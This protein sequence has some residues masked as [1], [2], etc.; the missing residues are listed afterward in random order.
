MALDIT[1]LQE[2][3]K[4]VPDLVSTT[5][6]QDSILNRMPV[7]V[8]EYPYSD[9]GK[10]KVRRIISSANLS[11]CC[12]INDGTTKFAE[13]EL[14]AVCIL[15][16]E[17]ICEADMASILRNG[18]IVYTA[19]NE[20]AGSL[21]ELIVREKLQAHIDAIDMLAFLGD[22]TSLDNNLNKLDGWITQAEASLAN[23]DTTTRA[24][25]LNIAT[26]NVWTAFNQ[27]KAALPINARKW[28]QVGVF[29]PEEFVDAY[30]TY[31]INANNFNVMPDLTNSNPYS[32][33]PVVGNSNFILVPVSALNGTGQYM[34]TPFK[35][36]VYLYSRKND[37]NTVSWR[38]SEDLERYVW[39]VK[40]IMGVGFLATAYVVFGE[41]DDSVMTG[42]FAVDVNIVSP[43]GANG[44]VATDDSGVAP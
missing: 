10:F 27:M 29:V 9:P 38:Y 37:V 35:N 1:G 17:T 11:D 15:D 7:A 39:R 18:D 3:I 31:F 21:G 43:L 30:N 41:I 32:N 5:I 33:R 44:G 23:T 2:F 40:H 16:R 36:L 4:L 28:G 34:M 8:N 14:E 25:Q 42:N 26:G 19:G 22:K 13:S 12:V 6:Y 24:T 20:S